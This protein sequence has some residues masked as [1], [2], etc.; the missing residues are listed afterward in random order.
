[1]E[2]T[3][4]KG[5][6]K[7][8]FKQ[9]QDMRASFFSDDGGKV[10][11][12]G[13]ESG[14]EG[15]Q[16]GKEGASAGTHGSNVYK[17]PNKA[18]NS[19][20]KSQTARQSQSQSQ[21]QA[22]QRQAAQTARPDGSKAGAGKDDKIPLPAPP[23]PPPPPPPASN[24]QAGGGGGVQLSSMVLASMAGK[25]LRKKKQ[26]Q[27]ELREAN[28][29][30]FPDQEDAAKVMKDDYVLTNGQI[31]PKKQMK[32]MINK[33][34]MVHKVFNQLS[35]PKDFD[36]RMVV[37]RGGRTEGRAEIQGRKGEQIRHVLEHFGGR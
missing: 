3:Q 35:K 34:A 36:Q 6:D 18:P 31:K 22:S 28:D 12:S 1:M 33:V 13:K 8:K 20:S 37:R 32:D 27:Q 24:K 10:G 23:P 25:L 5:K 9:Q 11:T 19:S 26:A 21:S 29:S 14:L 16:D 15:D 2:D 30:F 7:G 4:A 17:E